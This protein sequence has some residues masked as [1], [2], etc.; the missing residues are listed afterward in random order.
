[1][2]MRVTVTGIPELK[3]A[4]ERMNPGRNK[5]IMRNGMITAALEIQKNATG[6]IRK[7]GGGK[8]NPKPPVPHQLTSRT[9]TLRRSIRVNHGPLPFAIETGTDL[10]YGAVHEFHSIRPRPFLAPALK[11]VAPRLGKIFIAAWKKEA[12]L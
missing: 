4:L 6:Q 11:A 1:M 5:V 3:A 9:G 10:T 2:Q 7:G 12:R 8:K